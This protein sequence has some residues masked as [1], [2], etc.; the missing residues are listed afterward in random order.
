MV[1]TVKGSKKSIFNKMRDKIAFG[2]FYQEYLC[3]REE[4]GHSK[5]HSS[6]LLRLGLN[7]WNDYKS[8]DDSS[9]C[10]TFCRRCFIG[11]FYKIADDI[12][13]KAST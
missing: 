4:F 10:E 9:D 7:A 3:G 12:I 5:L 8:D 11:R 1:H 6:Q 2:L 13:Y